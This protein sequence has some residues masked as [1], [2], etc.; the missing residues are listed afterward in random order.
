[1]LR[2]AGFVVED[3]HHDEDGFGA[4]GTRPAGIE[5]VATLAPV[6]AD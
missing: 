3:A 4:V 1:M 5:G 6:A 2:D